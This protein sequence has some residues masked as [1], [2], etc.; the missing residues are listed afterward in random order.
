[1]VALKNYKYDLE[2]LAREFDISI[3][4]SNFRVNKKIKVKLI[5]FLKSIGVID[6]IDFDI[7]EVA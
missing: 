3:I 7:E 1:M 4:I 2:V 6:K 5:D